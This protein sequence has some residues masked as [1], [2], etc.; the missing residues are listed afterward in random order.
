MAAND[1]VG[2]ACDDNWFGYML[3]TTLSITV[4]VKTQQAIPSGFLCL[5]HANLHK[6]EA[7]ERK[8][9]GGRGGST[10]A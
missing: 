1:E 10:H 9:G 3:D 6:G 5:K 4:R 8:G 2:G 7:R